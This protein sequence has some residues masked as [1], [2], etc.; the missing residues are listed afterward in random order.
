M[1]AALGLQAEILWINVANGLVQVSARAGAPV[2][3]HV[4]V[5]APVYIS[6]RARARMRVCVRVHGEGNSELARM[7][8]GGCRSGSCSSTAGSKIGWPS[9]IAPSDTRGSICTTSS[10]S[11]ASS[12]ADSPS[13][14]PF[15]RVPC[16]SVH[17]CVCVCICVCIYVCIYVSICRAGESADT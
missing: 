9:S 5:L 7:T 6:A 16:P 4:C 3:V 12:A 10:S 13:S 2:P 8:G 17:L 14:G 11:L 1:D 15:L